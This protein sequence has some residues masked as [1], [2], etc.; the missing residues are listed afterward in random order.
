M[1]RFMALYSFIIIAIM[2]K[3]IIFYVSFQLFIITTIP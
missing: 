1:S 2:L 3:I